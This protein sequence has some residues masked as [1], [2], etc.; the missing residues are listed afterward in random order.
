MN[1]ISWIICSAPENENRVKF[2]SEKEKKSE[3]KCGSDLSRWSLCVFGRIYE[4]L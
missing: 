4:V 2:T 1:G 3:D